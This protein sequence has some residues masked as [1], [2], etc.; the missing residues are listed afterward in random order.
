MNLTDQEVLIQTAIMHAQFEIIHPF[1]DGNGRTGRILIPLYLWRK[2]RLS[3][4]MFYIS[5]FLD[6]NRD[7]YVES[8]HAIWDAQDW[9]LWI[10]FF[11]EAI[12][13]QAQRNAEKAD[14]VVNLYHVMQSRMAALTKSPHAMLVLDTL[15][16]NPIFKTP[17]FIKLTGIDPKS[18]HRL[19]ARLKSEGILITAQK[20]AGRSPEVLIFDELYQ[21]VR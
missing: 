19:I 9:E 12:V 18:A 14:Q 3:A 7:K 8:L 10:L 16:S 2:Q 6:E 5:E 4:P 17:E 1:C 13:I 11:L 20:H 15:F 21:L